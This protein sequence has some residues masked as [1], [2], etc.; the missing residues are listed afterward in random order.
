[1]L[2]KKKYEDD[3]KTKIEQDLAGDQKNFE[4]ILGALGEVI[5]EYIEENPQKVTQVY[6]EKTERDGDPE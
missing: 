1:M 5:K 4:V 3:Q 2:W 6:E